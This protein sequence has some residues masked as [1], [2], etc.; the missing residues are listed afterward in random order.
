[1]T[2]IVN[3]YK[4]VAQR[5][6][7]LLALALQLLIDYP[8]SAAGLHS[9]SGFKECNDA[10]N[11]NLDLILDSIIE[12]KDLNETDINSKLEKVIKDAANDKTQNRYIK[13]YT[14]CK[15]MDDHLSYSNYDDNND[16]SGDKRIIKISLWS[17]CGTDD[18]ESLTIGALNRNYVETSIWINPKFPVRK[19]FDL[20]DDG[21]ERER[22]IY[23]R[24]VPFGIN[25][26]LSNCSYFKYDGTIE[27]VNVILS[28]EALRKSEEGTF[29][30]AFAP[31][32]S[33]NPEFEKK[34]IDDF[35]RNGLTKRA[36][37]IRLL[38]SENKIYERMIR[39]WKLAI[40]SNA[41]VVFMPEM[42]GTSKVDGNNQNNAELTYQLIVE[43]SEQ[44]EN[45]PQ[46][47]VWP[48]YWHANT[49]GAMLTDKNGEI[50]GVQ[51]KHYPFIKVS[52][53]SE[54]AIKLYGRKRY[55]VIHIPN[56]HRVA[57]LI[58][59]EFLSDEKTNWS[60]ILCGCVGVSLLI[61]PSYS[62]GELDFINATIK[63]E[64][65]DTTVVWGN[66]CGA[67]RNPNK[68]VGAV[69]KPGS[70]TIE[71]FENKRTCEGCCKNIEACVFIVSLPLRAVIDKSAQTSE[72][73]EHIIEVSEKEQEKENELV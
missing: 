67:P 12:N 52:D 36:F 9:L 61:V 1:M 70:G 63:Y 43:Q 10:T 16:S 26:E 6:V 59:S 44:G 5:Y 32:T 39:D 55:F 3:A 54:E 65:F 7:D 69:T 62:P 58:C 48:S 30:I 46:L 25:G 41:N 72:I 33:D 40:K 53:N 37:E 35:D 31:I 2:T 22:Q 56:I 18:Y 11:K 47:T 68:C 64:Q 20:N 49:N 51:Y 15:W 24:D 17:L 42:L 27:I 4:N 50:L 60:K 38:D 14:I 57:V 29:K 34:Y 13:A 71:V 73:V 21:S 23:N 28:D 45:V 66:C 19:S 8:D